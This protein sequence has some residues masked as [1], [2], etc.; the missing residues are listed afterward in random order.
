[1]V[2]SSTAQIVAPSAGIKL[3]MD[4]AHEIIEGLDD[5]R[6]DE[7]DGLLKEALLLA[8]LN[9]PIEV[10]CLKWR[11]KIE[12]LKGNYTLARS[13]LIDAVEIAVDVLGHGH[14]HTL[15]LLEKH[16]LV[17]KCEYCE[18][19]L[20]SSNVR[21]KVELVY[22]GQIETAEKLGLPAVVALLKGD[23]AFMLHQWQQAC[24]HY[25]E[26][27]RLLK[28]DPTNSNLPR[29]RERIIVARDERRCELEAEAE[30]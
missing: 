16:A 17:I 20:M 15:R 26:A 1:M 25:D 18:Y 9:H 12:R 28:S 7:A 13:H 23:C 19:A 8:P 27:V 10:I 24:E 5:S 6:Y 11:A 3:L 2:T 14:A 30:V 21:P 22:N 29:L 4:E